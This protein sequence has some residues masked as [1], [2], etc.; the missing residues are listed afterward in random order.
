MSNAFLGGQYILKK[1]YLKSRYFGI[2]IWKNLPQYNFGIQVAMYLMQ[3][4]ILV[5]YL[6]F[7]VS[8]LLPLI[9]FYKTKDIF[10]WKKDESNF[11]FAKM[12]IHLFQKEQVYG[13]FF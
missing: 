13:I 12:I 1:M 6:D 2:Y 10:N 5:L 3:L 9:H 7:F 11:S 8:A 4:I